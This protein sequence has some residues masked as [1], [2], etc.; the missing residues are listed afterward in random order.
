[1]E[2]GKERIAKCE[3]RH[4]HYSSMLDELKSERE[5]QRK[6]LESMD[7]KI[8]DAEMML[9]EISDGLSQA[10]SLTN[11][12]DSLLEIQSYNKDSDF[13]R[14][15]TKGPRETDDMLKTDFSGMKKQE[16]KEIVD[17]AFSTALD[18]W[19][20]KDPDLADFCAS[21]YKKCVDNFEKFDD[22]ELYSRFLQVSC[23]P[24]SYI[25]ENYP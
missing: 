5:V 25:E 7:E 19:K 24:D 3:S 10:K 14:I 16:V 21:W 6:K 20:K 8:S 13:Y 22:Y 23:M 4:K 15:I 18:M 11:L 17:N 2:E 1:M 12:V 9:K